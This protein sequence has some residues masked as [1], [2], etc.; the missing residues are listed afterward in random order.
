MAPG[1]FQHNLPVK[2]VYLRLTRVRSHTHERRNGELARHIITIEY[3]LSLKRPTGKPTP[4]E[5]IIS[6]I[7][8]A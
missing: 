8:D 1:G 5:K 6:L 2:D 7:K 3:H 4:R